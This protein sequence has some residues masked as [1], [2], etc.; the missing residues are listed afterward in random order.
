MRPEERDL[1]Y[2]WDMREFAQNAVEVIQKHSF[3]EIE[4]QLIPRF[5]LERA[6]ELMGEAA[7]RVSEQVKNRH[8][9][10][11]W[12]RII[13]Q[14]NVIAHDYGEIDHRKLYDGVREHAGG[15]IEYL[16]RLLENA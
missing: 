13:G 8:R 11:D 10:I 15:L 5:A 6:L 4:N 12:K 9:G 2:L 16:D 7:R 3:E 1:A 14:R